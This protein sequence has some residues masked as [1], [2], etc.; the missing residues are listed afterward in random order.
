MGPRAIFPM[1]LNIVRLILVIQ[2]LLLLVVD[3]AGSNFPDEDKYSS[4]ASGGP[5]GHGILAPGGI[6]S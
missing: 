5:L 3:T 2:V 1:E 6:W 4:V